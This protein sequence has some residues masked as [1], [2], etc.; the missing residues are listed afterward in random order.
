[1][2]CKSP[3]SPHRGIEKSSSHSDKMFLANMQCRYPGSRIAQM[4]PGFMPSI[5]QQ[6]PLHLLFGSQPLRLH[7]ICGPRRG[8]RLDTKS[9]HQVDNGLRG[10]LIHKHHHPVPILKTLYISDN[11]VL[12]ASLIRLKRCGSGNV[13][14]MHGYI[15]MKEFEHLAVGTTVL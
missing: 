4:N 10:F 15:G 7:Q 8:H 14:N 5:A 11:D 3:Q 2:P 9:R 6:A 12:D 13:I 1:M